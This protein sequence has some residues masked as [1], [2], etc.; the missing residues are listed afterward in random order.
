VEVLKKN[1]SNKLA[2]GTASWAKFS[3]PRSTSSG[4]SLRDLRKQ[5]PLGRLKVPAYGLSLLNTCSFE[6]SL[7][8]TNAAK[9][10]STTNAAW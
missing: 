7:N 5:A 10:S 8:M 9:I 1:I 4:P 6:M 3:R 2:Y